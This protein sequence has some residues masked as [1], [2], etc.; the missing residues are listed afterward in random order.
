MKLVCLSVYML[1]A[2]LI[3]A[4]P[5]AHAG[6][7]EDARAIV[8]QFEKQHRGSESRRLRQLE[9]EL[10]A[11]VKKLKAMQDRFTRDSKLDEAVA[12][13]D[14]L[15]GVERAAEVG[16]A[17]TSLMKVNDKLPH[18]VREVIEDFLASYRESHYV[19]D[20]EIDGF[21]DIM[22]DGLGK[23]LNSYKMAEQLEE[24]GAI[25]DYLAIHAPGGIRRKGEIPAEELDAERK[26]FAAHQSRLNFR[27]AM[28]QQSL[29]RHFVPK[30]QQ[31]QRIHEKDANLGA[32]L[33]IREIID[34]LRQAE[35]QGHRLAPDQ[36]RSHLDRLPEDAGKLVS[37]LTDQ[38]NA[39]EREF[40]RTTEILEQEFTQ[41]LAP[42][43]YAALQTWEA[44]RS[45]TLLGELYRLQGKSFQWPTAPHR[46]NRLPLSLDVERI[47]NAFEGEITELLEQANAK[48]LKRRES[49][50][51][52]LKQVN[53]VKKLD[54]LATASIVDLIELLEADYAVGLRGLRLV[55]IPGTMPEPLDESAEAFHQA[56]K[57]LGMEIELARGQKLS[58]LKERLAPLRDHFIDEGD[59]ELAYAT[60]YAVAN[61]SPMFRPMRIKVAIG[62]GSSSA[63]EADL[64]EVK[65]NQLRI[66]WTSG[67]NEEWVARHRLVLD[68]GEPTK[69]ISQIPPDRPPPG[70]EIT[71]KTRL[72]AGQKCFWQWGSSWY[73]LTILDVTPS[74][75]LV[76]QKPWPAWPPKLLPRADL[77]LR[78]AKEDAR[79][80]SEK[81]D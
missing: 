29:R 61:L 7:P 42:H 58:E 57:E 6:L 59:L 40:R 45:L 22:S 27:H 69:Q 55:S 46:T 21:R 10:N 30:L 70:N 41:Q 16:V 65:D 8:D 54:K 44:D 31:C 78:A 66:R 2:S 32:A 68:N 11:T 26:L 9:V 75:V 51:A 50:I 13:R 67:H 72:T 49:L 23:L 48:E 47:I 73:E 39:D 20:R 64:L 3:L 63:S 56:A 36:L 34:L 43:V 76:D 14:H 19:R 38:L 1:C 60:I 80:Q 79:D 53:E 15:Q 25:R 52:E 18:E 28:T 71:S 77:R 33:A 74:G 37:D 12:I 24:A 17:S 62:S 5:Q 4:P 35:R 81:S